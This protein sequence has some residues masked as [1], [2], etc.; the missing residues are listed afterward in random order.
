MSYRVKHCRMCLCSSKDSLYFSVLF[1]SLV[2]SIAEAISAISTF[3]A[4]YCHLLSF[5]PEQPTVHAFK[6]VWNSLSLG[7]HRV[8]C[9]GALRGL[10]RLCPENCE[11]FTS[12]TAPDRSRGLYEQPSNLI[13][14]CNIVIDAILFQIGKSKYRWQ[15]FSG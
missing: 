3:A 1:Y 4:I 13:Q 8:A 14:Q 9:A 2:N 6:S 11:G 5:V 15:I 12:R 10:F 7:M